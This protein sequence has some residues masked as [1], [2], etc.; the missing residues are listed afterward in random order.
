MR[1]KAVAHIGQN[2]SL[3]CASAKKAIRTMTSM[4]SIPPRAYRQS[5]NG[6][7]CANHVRNEP[8]RTMAAPIRSVRPPQM[9]ANKQVPAR[10]T[11]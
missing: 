11:S 6:G 1:W 8:I 3:R 7:I 5:K 2:L 10:T 9:K 4:T